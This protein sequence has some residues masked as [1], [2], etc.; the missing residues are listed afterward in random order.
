MTK[1]A[2][3]GPSAPDFHILFESAPDPYLVLDSSLN[4]VAVSNAYLRAT[5]TVREQILGKQIFTVFPDNPDDPGA[6]GVR[7]LKLSLQRV[8]KNQKPDPMAVQKYDIKRPEIDGGGFE[9]RFWSPIN[10][11]IFDAQGQIIYII[12]RVEDVTDFVNLKKQGKET[13]KLT[14]ELR[15]KALRMETEIFARSK[16]VAATSAE[17]KHANAEL[18]VLYAK[19]QELDQLKTNFFANMSHEIRTPMNAILGLTYLLKR[20]TPTPEQDEKLDKIAVASRHLLS[21]INDILDFSKI[22]SGKLIL[23]KATFPAS[24]VLDHTRSLLED[25]AVAK[26]LT[27]EVEYNDIPVWLIGDQTRLRQALLN[28]AGN[29]IKFTEHGKIVLRGKLLED[30]GDEVLVRFEVADT[31]IGIEPDKISELFQAFKQ[32]DSSTTRKYGGTGLGLAITQKLSGLMG[33]SVGV[34]SQFGKGSTFW[35]TARLGKGTAIEIAKVDDAELAIKTNHSNAYILLVED[36]LI[37]QEVARTLLVDAGLRVDIAGDGKQAVDK[38]GANNYDLVLMDLQMPVMD[39]LEATKLI[40]QM[41]NKKSLP[42][43]ALTANIF[44][45]YR[46][47]CAEAGMNDFVG[48]PVEPMA[49]FATILKWLPKSVG[50]GIKIMT[51]IYQSGNHTNPAQVNLQTQLAKIEGLDIERGLLVTSGKIEKFWELLK[52]FVALH[53]D[54]IG[55]LNNLIDNNV[56]GEPTRIAH[57]LKGAAG[58]LGLVQIQLVATK[59]EAAF[60]AGNTK[61]EPLLSEIQKLL[62]ALQLRVAEIVKSD[63]APLVLAN[64]PLAMNVLTSLIPLLQSGSFKASQNFKEN[65]PLIRASIDRVLMASLE[66]AMEN[67]DFPGALKIIEDIQSAENS[68]QGVK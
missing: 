39:G 34:D 15:E 68:S 13:I 23:E 2:T 14:E 17:L 20:H 22:E 30:Y 50:G 12:H 38:V 28:Y 65:R 25:A 11:P 56:I 7:N 47:K 37:N 66:S 10:T 9:E 59:L 49:L 48:K 4:I 61:V 63:V 16:E 54:D 62:D 45:E 51:P 46:R 57:T 5:L 58:T 67:Y 8:L 29:S 19:T 32:V 24:A 18:K 64:F 60:S 55:R 1:E 27:I 3:M 41:P 52:D 40:R 31:G 36:D 33:G 6:E 35:F 21:I 44:E 26:G 43:L 42:I 53:Q